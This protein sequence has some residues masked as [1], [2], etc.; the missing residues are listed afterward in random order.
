[1]KKKF[2]NLSFENNIFLDNLKRFYNKFGI[3]NKEKIPFNI[4][5]SGNLDLI[6]LNMRFHEISHDK[7]LEGEDLR[8]IENE[9]NDVVLGEGYVS[10]LNFLNFKEFIKLVAT[11]IN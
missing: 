9:F 8:Y 2:T 4:F 7:K 6:N 1:M 5:V 3:Y 11:E 10:L